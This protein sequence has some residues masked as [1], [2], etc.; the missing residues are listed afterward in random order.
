MGEVKRYKHMTLF[1]NPCLCVSADDYDALRAENIGM[2][3]QRMAYAGE[4]PP[5][6]DGLPDTGSIHQNIRKLRAENERLR[7]VTHVMIPT[8]TMEQEFAKY[9]RRGFDAGIKQGLAENAEL[10]GALE[11]I[12]KMQLRGFITLGNE[13]TDKARAALAKH[14]CATQPTDKP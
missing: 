5:D 4:F 9:H 13:A 1:G 14:R 7:K 10:V 12:L 6:Q 2:V 3:A 11:H 8:D